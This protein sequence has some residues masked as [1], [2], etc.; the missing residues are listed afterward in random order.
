VASASDNTVSR[1]Q[2]LGAAGATVALTAASKAL[3]VRASEV[4]TWEG[5]TDVLVAGS[6][7]AGISAAIE[8]RAADAEV[9]VVE[10]LP[11]FGGA[12]AMSGGVVY[13]GGGTALQRALNIPDTAEQM[14]EFLARAGSV[15]PPLDKIQRYCEDSP[16]H[17]DWLVS[18][19]V[20]YSEKFTQ[21]K[22]LPLGDESLYYSGTELAWPSREYARPA[23]RGHVPGVPGMN[24]GRRLMQALLQSADTAGVR[25]LPGVDMQRL[26]VESDGRV[27]GAQ[28]MVDGEQRHYRARRG[29]VLACGGF[30][31]NREMV[32]LYAPQLFDCSVPWGN[33]AERGHGINMGIAAGA[34]ALRMH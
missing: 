19:G 3:A 5:E 11:Q 9:L 18:Q 28:L 22:G 33:A 8:A 17:F 12:S 10:T 4:N 29:V 1:R 13:A 16:A 2:L 14:Y 21:A 27:T 26:I 24:G 31:H 15:H 20:P 23:A 32:K 7:A 30:I 34:A 25:M 6:G